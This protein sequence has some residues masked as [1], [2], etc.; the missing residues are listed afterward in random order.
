MLGA[1]AACGL[2]LGG[3]ARAASPEGAGLKVFIELQD[4][5]YPGSTYTLIYD[6]L[7]DQFNGI[8]YQALQQQSFEV[9]FTRVKP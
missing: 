2:G 3:A 8:Y 4:V 5:N 6:P 9:F 1:V 7:N